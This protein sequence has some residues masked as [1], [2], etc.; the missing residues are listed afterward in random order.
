MGTAELE[1]ASVVQCKKYCF[2]KMEDILIFARL[3]KC[4]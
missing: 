1:I 3:K 2:V 4:P